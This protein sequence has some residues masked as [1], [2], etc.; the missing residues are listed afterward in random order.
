MEWKSQIDSQQPRSKKSK[1]GWFILPMGREARIRNIYESA[2]CLPFGYYR[3][4]G[5]LA[6][7]YHLSLGS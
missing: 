3:V 5:N 2:A 4:Y 1:F 7:I 6:A